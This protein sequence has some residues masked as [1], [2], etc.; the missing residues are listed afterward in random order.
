[1]AQLAAI[2]AALV[3]GGPG[4]V[5]A[6]DGEM[7]GQSPRPLPTGRA[8]AALDRDACLE[9]LRAQDVSFEPVATD[10]A[11]DVSMP[12]RITGPIGGIEVGRRSRR[13][14]DTILDCRLVV[15]LLAWAPT[16]RA[17]GVARIEH[18]SVYRPG[19]RIGRGRPSGHAFALAIDA[20]RFI[21]ADGRELDVLTDWPDKTRG[22]DPCAPREEEPE[23]QALLRRAVCDAVA[24]DLFQVVLTPHANAEHRNHLHLEVRP[25]VDWSYVR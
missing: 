24:R 6:Q 8:I 2:I 20:G 25:G 21:L 10:Q 1:M 7:E 16:L 17:A 14:E 18:Y 19:A 22:V 3:L 5:S 4:P 9:V 12:V 15:A 23:T 13:N 11:A